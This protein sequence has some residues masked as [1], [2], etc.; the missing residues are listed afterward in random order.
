MK[1]FTHGDFDKAYVKL[2]DGEKSRFK[3]RRSMFLNDPFYPILNNHALKGKYVGYRSI[4]IGGDL[5]AVFKMLDE[6]TA[7]FMDIDTHPN[8]YE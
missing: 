3:E 1:I 6:E 4:N 8:L 7:V 5:R 2:R